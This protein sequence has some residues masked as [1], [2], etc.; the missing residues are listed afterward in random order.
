MDRRQVILIGG[1]SE[2]CQCI[3]AAGQ[4]SGQKVSSKM[5]ERPADCECLYMAIVSTK[6]CVD[7]GWPG[8]FRSVRMTDKTAHSAPCGE[9][10]RLVFRRVGAEARSV[11]FGK[12]RAICQAQRL[13]QHKGLVVSVLGPFR[14]T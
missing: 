11:P 3:G 10:G 6:D 14:L 1:N 5:S 2:G 8:G 4:R 9:S 13:P 7:P 12:P